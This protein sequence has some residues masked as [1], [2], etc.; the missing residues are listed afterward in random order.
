MRLTLNYKF[1]EIPIKILIGYF[2]ELG[3][4]ILKFTWKRK[5]TK[6]VKKIM[7]KKKNNVTKKKKDHKKVEYAVLGSIWYKIIL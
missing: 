1:N 7:R 5:C 3:T 6:A 2:M 4:F